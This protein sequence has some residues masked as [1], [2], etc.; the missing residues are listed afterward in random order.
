LLRVYAAGGNASRGRVAFEDS[1]DT[2]GP[3]Y[4]GRGAYAAEPLVEDGEEDRDADEEMGPWD[5]DDAS[6]PEEEDEDGAGVD[7]GGGREGLSENPWE[8]STQDPGV[9]R[10]VSQASGSVPCQFMGVGAPVDP[11][12]RLPDGPEALL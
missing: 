6:L 3:G 9:L 10:F 2:L 11:S 4:P 7:E 5:V 8:E 12:S 1:H